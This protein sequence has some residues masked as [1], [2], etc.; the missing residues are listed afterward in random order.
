VAKSDALWNEVARLINI[1]FFDN[2]QPITGKLLQQLIIAIQKELTD[3]SD[4]A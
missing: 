1:E 2:G 3:N 4:S